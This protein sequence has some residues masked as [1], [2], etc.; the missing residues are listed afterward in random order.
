MSLSPIPWLKLNLNGTVAIV[1]IICREHI[2]DTGFNA[3]MDVVENREASLNELSLSR[4][5]ISLI[6]IHRM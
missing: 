3:L 1:W 6:F 5:I 2:G 4:S